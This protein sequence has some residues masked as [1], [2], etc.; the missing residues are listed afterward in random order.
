MLAELR[1]ADFRV[2]EFE[3][4]INAKRRAGPGGNAA[5]MLM[6][7]CSKVPR[8]QP[9]IARASLRT[10]FGVDVPVASLPD[11]VQG[12]LWAWSD[13]TRRESK[14]SKDE[15]DLLRL[16]EA[17]PE[18]VPMLPGPLRERLERQQARGIGDDAFEP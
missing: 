14:R 6:V 10:I 16:G 8:Y 15:S 11:V 9:F 4:S 7:Q 5:S 17:H 2:Q 3:F 12:K 13:P 18:I 1:A